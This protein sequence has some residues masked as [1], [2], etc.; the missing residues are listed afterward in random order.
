MAALTPTEL[1]KRLPLGDRMVKTIRATTGSAGAADEWIVTGLSDI[2]AILGVNI[3]GQ[4]G[5][6]AAA[7]GTV[8][9]IATDPTDEDTITVDGIVYTIQDGTLADYDVDMSTTEATMAANFAAAI[10][11]DDV[12]GSTAYSTNIA[13]H[14]TVRASVAGAVVT[15]TARVPGSGGNAITLAESSTGATVSGANLTGG[16]DSPSS[17]VFRKNAQGTG[18]AEDSSLGDLAVESAAASVTFE[19]TVLGRP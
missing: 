10:N 8:T 13:A 2:D 16:S 6:P 7:T 18:Q 5:V 11:R 17:V 19:V 12:Q 3:I 14:P 15:L 1:T 4:S 9:F